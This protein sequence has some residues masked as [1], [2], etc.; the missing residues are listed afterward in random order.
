MGRDVIC[1][2]GAPLFLGAFRSVSL[3]ISGFL[4]IAEFLKPNAGGRHNQA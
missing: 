1:H 2:K 3:Y 4:K